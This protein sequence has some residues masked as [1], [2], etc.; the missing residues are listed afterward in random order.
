MTY[1]ENVTDRNAMLNRLAPSNRWEEGFWAYHDANPHVYARFAELANQMR[2]TGRR[3]YSSATIISV[4]RFE[5]D[6]N[7]D[8]PGSRFKIND[9]Y[10]AYYARLFLINNPNVPLEFF[11]MRTIR[12]KEQA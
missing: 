11:E 1:T 6:L 4:I 10:S 3:R 7:A 8:D 2:E 12:N 9:G 5:T